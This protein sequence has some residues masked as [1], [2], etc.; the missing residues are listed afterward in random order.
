MEMAQTFPDM[1]VI[2]VDLEPDVPH[3]IQPGMLLAL[4]ALLVLLISP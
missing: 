4:F 2:G 3:S 1:Q